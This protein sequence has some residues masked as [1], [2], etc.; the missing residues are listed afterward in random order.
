MV[1]IN[2]TRKYTDSKKKKKKEKGEREDI[3]IS[4]VQ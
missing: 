3:L 2:E 1:D 4:L